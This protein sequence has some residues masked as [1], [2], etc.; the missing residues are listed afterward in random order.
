[1]GQIT[2]PDLPNCFALQG[3]TPPDATGGAPAPPLRT[4]LRCRRRSAGHDLHRALPADFEN[5]LTSIG[6]TAQRTTRP[7]GGQS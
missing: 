4:G 2:S 5:R 6:T 3:I 7:N 1:M